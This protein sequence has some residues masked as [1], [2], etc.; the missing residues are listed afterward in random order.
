MEIKRSEEWD[1]WCKSGEVFNRYK[2]V[3]LHKKMMDKVDADNLDI[4]SMRE[5]LKEIIK[6]TFPVS[7]SE[8]ET[9]NK[10]LEEK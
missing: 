1:K 4:E 9:I 2:H 8:L 5:I 6:V 10:I 7:E 3:K